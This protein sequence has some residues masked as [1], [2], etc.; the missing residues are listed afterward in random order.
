MDT[1]TVLRQ[2]E[3]YQQTKDARDA[4]P[5][6]VSRWAWIYRQARRVGGPSEVDDL[7]QAGAL[8]L[9]ESLT[10][11]DLQG[12]CFPAYASTVARRRMWR[13]NTQAKRLGRLQTVSLDMPILEDGNTTFHDVLADDSIP[14]PAFKLDAATITSV[15]SGR[16]QQIIYR[17]YLC[18]WTLQEV[19]EELGLT[20]ERVRQIEV[21][22][23]DRLRRFT[24]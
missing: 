16:E 21:Q 23:M 19:G 2:I 20:R 13:A 17:R 3:R 4:N 11:F 24:R 5:V 9:W 22:A 8:A 1:Q 18:Q 10:N 14:D 7:V 15:L 6:I 12:G